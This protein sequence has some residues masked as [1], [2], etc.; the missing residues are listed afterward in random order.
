[1]AV[2]VKETPVLLP[3]R[4]HSPARQLLAVQPQNAAAAVGDAAGGLVGEGPTVAPAFRNSVATTLSATAMGSCGCHPHSFASCC[5]Q[6]ACSTCVAFSP[7]SPA[8]ALPLPQA[9]TRTTP[10]DLAG[11][12]ACR[13]CASAAAPQTGPLEVEDK[14]VADVGKSGCGVDKQQ[15]HQQ[16][17]SGS[18]L[19]PRQPSLLANRRFSSC[20]ICCR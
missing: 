6:L 1:M 5:T 14:C 17:T 9:A 19:S 12:T 7:A 11:C 16:Q 18:T 10:P 13:C 15:R 20:C 3:A 4:P 2:C 8:P